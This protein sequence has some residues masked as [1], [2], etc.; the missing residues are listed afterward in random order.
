MATIKRFKSQRFEPLVLSSKRIRKNQQAKSI[1]FTL[2]YSYISN[3]H[4]LLV[5][6]NNILFLFNATWTVLLLRELLHAVHISRHQSSKTQILQSQE[7]SPD[8]YKIV[9]KY[10][11]QP[12]KRIGS[13]HKITL[14]QKFMQCGKRVNKNV[15]A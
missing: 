14:P 13:I 11:L 10:S 1:L 5:F 3:I 6:K 15:T 8:S 4:I 2:Y 7:P 9:L 12:D